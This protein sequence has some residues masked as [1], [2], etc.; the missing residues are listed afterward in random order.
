MG[1]PENYNPK[2]IIHRI[3][4]FF[5]LVGIGLF[6]IFMLSESSNQPQFNYFCGSMTLV[7]LGF[8]FRAQYKKTTVP[9]GR[10]SIIKKLFSRGGQKED[11]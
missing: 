4:T 10:F 1:E 5:L 3:G 7:T 6:V 8:L 9:S 2:E 11:E